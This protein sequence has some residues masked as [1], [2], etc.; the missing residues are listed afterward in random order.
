MTSPAPWTTGDVA[1]TVA[2]LRN[3]AKP[4]TDDVFASRIVWASALG[5]IT[6]IVDTRHVDDATKVEYVRTITDAVRQALQ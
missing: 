3:L 1:G 5:I 4:A 6:A 2:Y